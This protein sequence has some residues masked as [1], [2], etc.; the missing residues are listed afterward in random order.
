MPAKCV[1]D[2]IREKKIEK[3]LLCRTFGVTFAVTLNFSFMKE[4]EEKVAAEGKFLPGGILKVDSF[5]N[6]QID[7]LLM[8]RVGAEIARLFRDNEPKIDKVVTVEASGIA[9]AMA[10]ALALGV[11]MVFFKKA[12]P[13]TM[14][15]CY[16]TQVHSAT[17]AKNYDIIVDCNYLKAG[18]R[19]LLVDDFLANGN[20]TFGV[21]DLCH[22]AGAE[23]VGAAFLV[24]KEFMEGRKRILAK[25]PDLRIESLAIV[26]SNEIGPED[27]K[28]MQM[29]ID[30]SVENV[31][32]GGGPFGAV[33]VKDGQ[34]VATGV[35]RVT[36]NNDPTAHAE[37]SAIRNACQKLGSFKLDGCVIYTSCEPCP[38]CL[39]AIY[40]SGIQKI[41]YG[42]T[43]SDAKDID[44][45]DQFI[46]D[47]IDRT[48]DVRS[49]PS[50]CMMRHEAQAAFREWRL[51]VDKIEY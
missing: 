43:A 25:Y 17:K 20:A 34:L 6:H 21:L 9:P 32:N 13:T 19:V 28:F 15:R 5:I 41:Y 50:I 10:A 12:K 37:V 46:Y 24:E 18:E 3:H 36:A 31:R 8:Q 40:W 33:I 11:P 45:D 4:L 16:Q 38:M 49:I 26:Q 35:N 47:E 44:F 29:A 2:G 23:L 27:E 51:K 1:E 14:Q 42:N 7:P 39:S 22:Q 30:A 48:A